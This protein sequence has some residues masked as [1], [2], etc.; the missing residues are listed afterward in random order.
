MFKNVAPREP[1]EQLLV[2]ALGELAYHPLDEVRFLRYNRRERRKQ[3]ETVDIKIR[4]RKRSV[5]DFEIENMN[6]TSEYLRRQG[7][8]MRG[9]HR[10]R[11]SQRRGPNGPGSRKSIEAFLDEAFG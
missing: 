4:K 6:K 9:I 5:Q 7:E 2:D 1:A 8:A 11:P 3:E 10:I